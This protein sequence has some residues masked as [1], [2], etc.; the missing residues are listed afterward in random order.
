MESSA[1]TNLRKNKETEFFLVNVSEPKML[2][3]EAA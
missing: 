3:P 2:W 1:T